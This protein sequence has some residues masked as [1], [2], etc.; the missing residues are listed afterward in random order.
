MAI[1]ILAGIFVPYG[2]LAGSDR[3]MAVLIFWLLFGV[4]VIGLIAIG[5]MRW[6]DET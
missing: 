1:A 4:V 5:V 6:R 3:A 2:L